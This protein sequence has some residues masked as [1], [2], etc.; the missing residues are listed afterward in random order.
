[1]RMAWT[2]LK[3]PLS[4]HERGLLPATRVACGGFVPTGEQTMIDRRWNISFNS[5]RVTA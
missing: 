2:R 3:G 1:M 5:R 4:E